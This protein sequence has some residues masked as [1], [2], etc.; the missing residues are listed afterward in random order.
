MFRVYG[1]YVD[2][3]SVEGASNMEIRPLLFILHINDIPNYIS[4]V[5]M[6]L[7]G[8]DISIL[9]VNKDDKLKE[10][11]TR[12]RNHLAGLIRMS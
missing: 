6:V 5:R 2:S 4:D 8:D 12:L 7:Y 1:V 10:K 3:R 9:T 11:I